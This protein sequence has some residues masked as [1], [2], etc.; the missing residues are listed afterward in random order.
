MYFNTNTLSIAM[1]TTW[2]SLSKD[3]MEMVGMTDNVNNF[4]PANNLFGCRGVSLISKMVDIGTE[5]IS[6]RNSISINVPFS[7]LK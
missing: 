4:Y 1:A 3:D 5:V 2:E 6:K 7:L